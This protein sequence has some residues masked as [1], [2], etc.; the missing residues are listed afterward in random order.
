MFG[1]TQHRSS[2]IASSVLAILLLLALP[3]MVCTAQDA[4]ER[5]I[6]GSD[7]EICGTQEA[8]DLTAEARAR[9]PLYCP[10]EQADRDKAAQLYIEAIAAQPGARIN[11]KLADR[12][13]QMY[14]FYEDKEKAVQP[15]RSKASQW[16]RR[17]IEFTDPNQLVWAQAQ[18]GLASM[19]VWGNDFRSALAAYN[20]ILEIDVKQVV[21]PRWKAWSDGDSQR[22]RTLLE[23]ERA[24]LR[25]SVER[26]QGRAVEKVFYVLCRTSRPGALGVLQNLAVKYSGTPVGDRAVAL[27]AEIHET[28]G[29]DPLDLLGLAPIAA[30]QEE[31]PMT[32]PQHEEKQDRRAPAAALPVAAE[33]SGRG[34]WG[35]GIAMFAAVVALTV[36]M[37]IA[38]CRSQQQL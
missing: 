15:D 36:G 34:R 18:M 24:R 21:L 32:P 5:I 3:A 30:T 29:A 1:L 27:M 38:R 20:K 28:T 7:R 12:V 26:I 8:A 17:C 6:A 4:Q 19:A 14:A 33:V 25:E 23:R 31:Q 13:A 2:A 9:D 22:N 37:G 35:L 10:R 11:A 16:W